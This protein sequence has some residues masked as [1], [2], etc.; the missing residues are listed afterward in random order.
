MENGG[1][2]TT[3][4]IVSLQITQIRYSGFHLF[5]LIFSSY[6]FTSW[7]LLTFISKKLVFIF[8]LLQYPSFKNNTVL[9]QAILRD[10]LE[11]NAKI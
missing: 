4:A 10:D 3:V 9:W 2:N 1:E 11:K 5:W 7:K 6:G 8:Q